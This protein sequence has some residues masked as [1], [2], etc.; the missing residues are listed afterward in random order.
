MSFGWFPNHFDNLSL[1]TYILDKENKL[2]N[3]RI[4]RWFVIL[5]FAISALT[6]CFVYHDRDYYYHHGWGYHHYDRDD[7]HHR[8]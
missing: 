7:S 4:L 8:H 6:G 3:A 5:I 1:S 2:M